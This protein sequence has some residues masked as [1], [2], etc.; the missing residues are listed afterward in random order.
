M[1]LIG[2]TGGPATGKSRVVESLADCGAAVADSD[3]IVHELYSRSQRLRDSVQNRWGTTVFTDRGDVDR[4]RVAEIVF[5]SAPDREWLNAQIH[6][7]VWERLV[8]LERRRSPIPVYCAIPLLFEVGWQDRVDG[9]VGVWCP[10]PVQRTRL[11]ERGWSAE[12]IRLCIEAQIPAD[13][14]LER[15]DYG[16]INSG[17]TQS[18]HDQ[19]KAVKDRIEEG[20]PKT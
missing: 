20:L 18:L 15:A 2:I 7:L 16:I 5:R 4:R 13:D 6:P 11:G 17:S 3:Q 14:K 8:D 19:C 10:E 1:A 12:R 9:S